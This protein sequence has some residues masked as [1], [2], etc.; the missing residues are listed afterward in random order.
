MGGATTS[1]VFF[2]SLQ[3]IDFQRVRLDFLKL[4][5]AKSLQPTVHTRVSF[6][7]L[8]GWNKKTPQVGRFE[9]EA[10]CVKFIT[11]INSLQVILNEI[12]AGALVSF[13]TTCR[14]C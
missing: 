7:N 11:S 3:L 12:F 5:R 6:R 9:R 2:K 8:L 14:S 4:I 10:D 13:Q 1:V